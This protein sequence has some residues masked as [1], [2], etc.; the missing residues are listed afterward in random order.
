MRRRDDLNVEMGSSG[1][2]SG[3]SRAAALTAARWCVANDHGATE[4][5]DLLVL[6]LDDPRAAGSRRP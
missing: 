5:R 2:T 3:Q 6:L 4:L 1:I